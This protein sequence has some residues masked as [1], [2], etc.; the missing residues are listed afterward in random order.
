MPDPYAPQLV[1]VSPSGD[2]T[3]V[4]DT[5]AVNAVLTAQ[6]NV[7]TD[8]AATYTANSAT[9]TDAAAVASDVGKTVQVGGITATVIKVQPTVNLTLSC[10]AET[11]GTG[12]TL[13]QAQSVQL[14]AGDYFF[15]AGSVNPNGNQSIVGAGKSSTTINVVGTG[16]GINWRYSLYQPTA[17]PGRMQGFT[18][19]PVYASRL[20]TNGIHW[21]DITGAMFFDIHAQNFQG[22]P[23][24]GG[25]GN[26][27]SPTVNSAYNTFICQSTTTINQ[28][29]TTVSVSGATTGLPATGSFTLVRAGNPYQVNYTNVSGSTFTGCT[30]ASGSVTPAVGDS[31]VVNSANYGFGI[32]G[33][34]KAAAT[35]NN[36]TAGNG[37]RA[38][39]IGVVS[40]SNSVGVCFDYHNGNQSFDYNWWD[41][42]GS[43]FSQGSGGIQQTLVL[44][45]N[46]VIQ[47]HSTLFYRG[48][49]ASSST[50][51]VN[52]VGIAVV[53]GSA[54]QGSSLNWQ[55]E[56]GANGSA[57][58]LFIDSV[59]GTR[60]NQCNGIIDFV[61]TTSSYTPAATFP[62]ITTSSN[63][64]LPTTV[65]LPTGLATSGNLIITRAGVAYQFTYTGISGT[66]FTGVNMV[67][68][69]VSTFTPTGTD[70]ITVQKFAPTI[71]GTFRFSSY[72]GA[73]VNGA[74]PTTA[75]NYTLNNDDAGVVVTAS[76]QITLP[77]PSV[78]VPYFHTHFLFC[79]VKMTRHDSE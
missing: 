13:W 8:G 36:T 61:Q 29:G 56:G 16:D 5:T 75:S 67:A 35:V 68:G 55:M 1:T 72:V 37:E 40:Y 25:S 4:A 65:T 10:N 46:S 79:C 33:D 18:I 23:N 14:V 24:G 59:A 74:W 27:S 41:V 22:N 78:A 76:A 54:I 42:K 63:S 47:T 15:T 9:V 6:P 53:N 50:G 57:S 11:S 49:I 20:T 39:A 31:I 48:N 17:V 66:G 62:T 69:G 45:R 70:T 64:T 19:Q 7:R 26:G 3:G 51:V 58:P 43:T 38:I 73:D 12:I 77:S 71:L 44:Y 34:N 52:T 2:T 60:V 21:G 28:S 30:I 32:W